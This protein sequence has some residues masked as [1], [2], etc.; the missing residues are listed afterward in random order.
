[1]RGKRLLQLSQSQLPNFPQP[2]QCGGK[3]KSSRVCAHELI[4]NSVPGWFFWGSSA[5]S[6]T[7][8]FTILGHREK[9]GTICVYSTSRNMS[10]LV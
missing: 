6:K 4:S 5:T 9:P 3:I 2:A 8:F 7:S 1:M 10:R